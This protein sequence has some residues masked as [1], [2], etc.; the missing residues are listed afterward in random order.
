MLKPHFDGTAYETRT[1]PRRHYEAN[2]DLW[3][4]VKLYRSTEGKLD[5]D[6]MRTFSAVAAEALG[7]I[8]SAL[9][10]RLKDEAKQQA[11][12]AARRPP[13]ADAKRGGRG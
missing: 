8:D 6:G 10:Y 2:P 4:L 1:C 13:P 3:P 9:A 5:V 7:I 11:R 12:E